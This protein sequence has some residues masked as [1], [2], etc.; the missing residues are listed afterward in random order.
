[1]VDPESILEWHDVGVGVIELDGL[2]VVGLLSR[3]ER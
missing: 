3:I 1:M 2:L